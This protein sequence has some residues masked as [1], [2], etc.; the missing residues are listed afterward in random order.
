MA[1]ADR[2]F[3]YC[4]SWFMA[5][6]PCC[7][8]SRCLLWSDVQGTRSSGQHHRAALLQLS[9]QIT[10]DVDAL[11]LGQLDQ[12]QDSEL[13]NTKMPSIDSTMFLV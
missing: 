7:C 8:L 2:I 12:H 9:C 11:V 4:S 6:S 3:V 10:M 1:D 13:R 5:M